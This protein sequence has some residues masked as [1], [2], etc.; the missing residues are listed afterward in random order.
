MSKII[1]AALVAAALLTGATAAIADTVPD[2]SDPYGGYD[3][4][5]QEGNRAFWEQQTRHGN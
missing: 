2:Q 5:S 4:N 3:H 1:R